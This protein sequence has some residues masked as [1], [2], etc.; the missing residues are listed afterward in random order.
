MNYVDVHNIAEIM[1]S[2]DIANTY[3]ILGNGTIIVTSHTNIHFAIE[4]VC[5]KLSQFVPGQIDFH[6]EKLTKEICLTSYNI[7]DIYN[8]IDYQSFKNKSHTYIAVMGRNSLIKDLNSPKILAFVS[9]NNILEDCR[10]YKLSF[11]REQS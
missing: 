4:D 1:K 5:S 7:K 11:Q 10:D 8:I 2:F 9:N 3:L 6:S